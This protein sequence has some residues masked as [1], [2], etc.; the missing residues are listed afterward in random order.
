MGLAE[1]LAELEERWFGVE[2]LQADPDEGAAGR[3]QGRQEMNPATRQADHAAGRQSGMIPGGRAG[4]DG[5]R[6]AAR[7]AY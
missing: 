6:Q 1:G 7:W 4:R 2:A 3:R 5:G